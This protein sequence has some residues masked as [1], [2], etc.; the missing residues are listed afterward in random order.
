[1]NSCFTVMMVGDCGSAPWM[2]P[3]LFWE[4]GVLCYLLSLDAYAMGLTASGIGSF[5][6]KQGT[7]PPSDSRLPFFFLTFSFS[8][9][10][11]DVSIKNDE[12]MQLTIYLPVSFFQIWVFYFFI[13]ASSRSRFLEMFLKKSIHTYVSW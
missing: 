7:L 9:S 12:W 13:F 3:Q 8:P 11:F 10:L 2:Y 5:F 4:A 6:D 1:M